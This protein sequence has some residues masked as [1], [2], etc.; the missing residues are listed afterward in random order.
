MK[1]DRF[2]VEPES[3][4]FSL[5]AMIDVLFLMI[6]F[7]VLG[8]NFDSVAS[9]EL[10]ASRGGKAAEGMIRVELPADGGALL[11]GRPMDERQTVSALR[12][13]SPRA[14]LLLPDRRLSVDA[15][16]RWYDLLGRELGVPVSVG[17]NPP[18]SR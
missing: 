14:V 13:R 4:F 12:R 6:I 18:T 5:T 2:R 8:A 7:L 9:V 11:D 17:V 1:L 3:P 16:F 15:L 10:P